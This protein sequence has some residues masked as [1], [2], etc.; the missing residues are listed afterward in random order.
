MSS[1]DFLNGQREID[2]DRNRPDAI[3]ELMD[4]K[5]IKVRPR[6]HK[7]LQKL[8]EKVYQQIKGNR[9]TFDFVLNFLVDQSGLIKR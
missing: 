1:L 3:T 5:T 6:T 4:K 9:P 2:P 8:K 7:R